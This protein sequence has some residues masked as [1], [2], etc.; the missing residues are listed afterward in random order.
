MHPPS[1]SNGCV[2]WLAIP[3]CHAIVNHPLGTAW[4]GIRPTGREEHLLLDIRQVATF[5]VTSS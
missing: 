5:T 1:S 4:L 3:R 2:C